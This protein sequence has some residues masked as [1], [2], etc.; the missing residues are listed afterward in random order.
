MSF[1]PR[2]RTESPSCDYENNARRQDTEASRCCECSLD[3]TVIHSL[4][5]VR[6][7]YETPPCSSDDLWKIQVGATRWSVVT[8]SVVRGPWSVGGPWVVNCGWPVRWSVGRQQNGSGNGASIGLNPL[9]PLLYIFFSPTLSPHN[10]LS[11]FL[12]P[13]ASD[14]LEQQSPAYYLR[15]F[16]TAKFIDTSSSS[17]HR[18]IVASSH[19]HIVASSHRRIL[20]S[21]RRSCRHILVVLDFD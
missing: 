10:H 12:H 9:F 17:S 8:W 19:R 7:H 6:T 18:R 4:S 1:R 15:I 11:P 16:R 3:Y 5:V 20:A 2:R 21:S 14:F 13:R